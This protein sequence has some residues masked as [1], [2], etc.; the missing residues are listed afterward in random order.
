M[1]ACCVSGQPDEKYH[2]DEDSEASDDEDD[3]EPRGKHMDGTAHGDPKRKMRKDISE[4]NYARRREF[5]MAYTVLVSHE[6]C[7]KRRVPT[8]RSASRISFST[9]PT[10]DALR[11]FAGNKRNRVCALNFANGSAR[12]VG[13]GY[14]RGAKAQEEDLCR[15]IPNLFPSLLG[16]KQKGLYPFGPGTYKSP[17]E[18]GTYS[19]VLFTPLLTLAR[20]GEEDGYELYPGGQRSWVALVSAAAPNCQRGECQDVNLLS[21]TVH[22]IFVAPKLKQPDVN[23]LILGAWGCGAFAGNPEQTCD[24]FIAALK[25]DYLGQ[26]YDEIHFAVPQFKKEDV[27][28]DVFRAALK[29]HKVTFQELSS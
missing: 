11:H 8:A 3:K 10:C 23:V 19:D 7:Q 27:N 1:F 4:D 2:P 21:N 13:G 14:K 5:K 17:T 28:A 9:L 29:K 20:K 26:L 18:P 24:L 15:R 6:E 16:A 22:S 25:D 12:H